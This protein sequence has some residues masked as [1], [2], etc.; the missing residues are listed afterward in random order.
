M[1]AVR[2]LTGGDWFAR[3]TSAACL[4]GLCAPF[5]GPS[6]FALL[7]GLFHQQ[8]ICDDSPTVR[9]AATQNLARLIQ[10]V[11]SDG[12]VAQEIIPMLEK[13]INDP[14]DSVRVH[15]IEPFVGLLERLLSPEEGFEEREHLLALLS[16]L[17]G[18]LEGDQSWRIQHVLASHFGRISRA[19][20]DHQSDID[21]MAT[22]C[23]LL[24]HHEPEVRATAAGQLAA[25]A[26]TATA[27]Q[28]HKW[29]IPII[30]VA[31]MD[32]SPH[33]KAALARQLNTVSLSLG[34]QQTLNHLLPVIL[35]FLHDES[36]EVRLNVIAGLETTVQVI[37]IDQLHQTLLP[38]ISKL[39]TDPQWRVRRDVVEHMPSLARLLGQDRFD[40]GMVELV[41]S[42]LDDPVWEVRKTAAVCI[43]RIVKGFQEDNGSLHSHSDWLFQPEPENG[44][45][46]SRLLAL[47]N[48]PNYL[49]RQILVRTIEE[50]VK[51]VGVART[52]Q[53]LLPTLV[54][55]ARDPIANVRFAVAKALEHML[56]PLL[57]AASESPTHDDH[58]MEED[59]D[60]K[61]VHRVDSI[62]KGTVIP[63]LQELNRDADE[64]VVWFSEQALRLVPYF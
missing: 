34:P 48:H 64:D 55:L 51:V 11:E 5:L 17:Y 25:V 31:A 52:V 37:G 27:P 21:P 7:L 4:G 30:N 63:L 15:V 59:D 20:K 22:F 47:A 10:V 19:L 28:I 46:A 61:V 38:A 49:R 36:S 42:W 26:E 12:L 40:A 16:P 24:D 53:Y 50:L 44:R 57:L 54:G 23:A 14:Q 58:A 39:S 6:D 33:V 1:G 35:R 41:L 3:K 29:I 43:G 56:P 18:L 32:E 8:L 13:I 2:N 60:A 45:L 62:I 9:K